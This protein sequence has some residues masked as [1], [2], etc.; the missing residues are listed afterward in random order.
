MQ[1]NCP[2]CNPSIVEIAFA[3]ESGFYALYNHAPV[4]PGHSLIIPYKHVTSIFSLNDKEFNDLFLFCR[5]VISF[6]NIYYSTNEFDMSLQEGFN[7]GQSVEHLHIHIIPRRA[8][9]LPM[10]QEWF[11]KLNEEKIGSLDSKNFLSS[12]ELNA[13]S[14]KLREAWNKR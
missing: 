14:T 3:N 8:N 10:G 5:K 11:H 6:L 1:S 2:F 7:A 13:I 4:V 12:E 9:D